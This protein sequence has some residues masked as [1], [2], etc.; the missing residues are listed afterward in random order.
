MAIEDE[1]LL[2]EAMEDMRR[3][4][5][6]LEEAMAPLSRRSAGLQPYLEN[7]GLA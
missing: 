1:L 5:R 6:D 7:T 3:K 2:E 4:M